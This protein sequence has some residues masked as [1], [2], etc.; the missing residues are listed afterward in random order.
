LRRL[1]ECLQSACEPVATF[2]G[3]GAG[4][5]AVRT[6]SGT[7]GIHLELEKKIARFKKSEACVEF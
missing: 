7:M 6:I 2:D 5:G 1:C 3:N 4:S